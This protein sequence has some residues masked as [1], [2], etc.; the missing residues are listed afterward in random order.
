MKN[1]YAYLRLFLPVCRS[2]QPASGVTKKVE[3]LKIPRISERLFPGNARLGRLQ[4]AGLSEETGW[5]ASMRAH[6]CADPP[7]T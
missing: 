3:K 4:V 5:I 1:I 2:D 7:D 6:H